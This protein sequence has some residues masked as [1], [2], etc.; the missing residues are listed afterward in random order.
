MW[1]VVEGEGL[2][3]GV[4]GGYVWGVVDGVGLLAGV[5]GG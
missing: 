4:V 3:D 2:L 5:C 1:G